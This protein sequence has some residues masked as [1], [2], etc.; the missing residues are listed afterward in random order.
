MLLPGDMLVN[1][2]GDAEA[3]SCRREGGDVAVLKRADAQT[4]GRGLQ[5]SL[6]QCVGRAHVDQGNGARFAVDA[7]GLDDA[8]VGVPADDVTLEASHMFC[9]YTRSTGIV[10]GRV[11]H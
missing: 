9:V 11:W 2:G 5:E 3:V 8:P 1:Q 10:K 6:E 7:A 4:T